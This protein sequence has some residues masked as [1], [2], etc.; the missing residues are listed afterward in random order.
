MRTGG[1]EFDVDKLAAGRC[2]FTFTHGCGRDVFVQYAYAYGGMQLKDRVEK[3]D[4]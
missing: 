3:V 2:S 4:F 1:V